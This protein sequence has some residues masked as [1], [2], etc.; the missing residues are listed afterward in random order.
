MESKA[1]PLQ[2]LAWYTVNNCW[3]GGGVILT[4][5]LVCRTSLASRYENKKLH[6]AIIDL[7]ATRL[8]YKHIFLSDTGQDLD[9]G[10]ALCSGQ[11]TSHEMKEASTRICELGE[12]DGSW[13]HAQI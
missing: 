13:G 4:C 11:F 7:G 1:E 12:L 8:H 3:N 6:Y 10:L 2:K 9:T 5:D